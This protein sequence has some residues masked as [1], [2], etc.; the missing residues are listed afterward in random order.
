MNGQLDIE[1]RDRT[2]TVNPGEILVVLK[3]VEHKPSAKEKTH[4]LLFEPI[5]T[6]HTGNVMTGITVDMYE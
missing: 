5:S 2:M 3:G 6:K 1:M 4:L